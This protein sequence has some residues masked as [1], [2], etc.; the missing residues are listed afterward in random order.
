MEEI[1]GKELLV[2]TK[3]LKVLY[4]E[5]T[6]E[7]REQ[8][9]ST[10]KKFFDTL[11]V[12]S[13][14]EEGFEKFQTKDY[15]L[16]ISDIEMPKLSGIEMAK[17]IKEKK[18]NQKI[19]FTTAYDDSRYYLETIKLGVNGYILKPIVMKQFYSVLYEIAQ[20]II[21]EKEAEFYKLKLEKRVEEEVEKNRKKDQETI[22]TFVNLLASYPNPTIVY[23]KE[24]SK[25]RFINQAA[26]ESLKL[27]ENG[28]SQD[29]EN[30]IVEFDGKH[31][32]I[33]V[34][35]ENK[36]T[37]CA[38]KV[39]KKKK[40]Y[41]IIHSVVSLHDKQYDM[42]TFNDIT[43]EKYQKIKIRNYSEWLSDYVIR[44]R[45]Q[46][47]SNEENQETQEIDESKTPQRDMAVEE[48]TLLRKSNQEKIAAIDYI[49]TID[50]YVLEQ[51]SELEEIEDEIK[52]LL[53]EYDESLDNQYIFK[54]LEML[55]KYT[56]T[57]SLLFEFE[58]LAFAIRGIGI[59]KEKVDFDKLDNKTRK[60]CST[61]I[62]SVVDD[63]VSWRNHIFVEKS[64][65]D[66]HYLDSSL[67]SSCLQL[68][69]TLT[70][71]NVESDESDELELF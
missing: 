56:S 61:I 52:D 69:V 15:D 16:V 32:D 31:P 10:L 35:L 49:E 51:I 20:I 14:G 30:I 50:D 40:I 24:D 33:E 9:A 55:F 66:I 65:N 2:I 3:D 12:C 21:N 27:C 46:C 5:D 59:L 42:F 44:A 71:T 54:A 19:I 41:K 48:K 57:I 64:T 11:D 28:T 29:L 8:T 47:L 7:T 58:D 18:P 4:V 36:V 63:L 26:K 25:I 13:N 1:S 53:Y 67:F 70:G 6:E 62:A 45:K 22:E 68:E 60:S 17:K 38:I 39:S 34:I 43:L 37:I 23:S